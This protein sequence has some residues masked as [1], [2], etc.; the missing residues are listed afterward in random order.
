MIQFVH[1]IWYRFGAD[2]IVYCTHTGS[3]VVEFNSHCYQSLAAL[4]QMRGSFSRFCR[5]VIGQWEIINP[6]MEISSIVETSVNFCKIT[7]CRSHKSSS[8]SPLSEPEISPKRDSSFI[9]SFPGDVATPLML[10]KRN[11]DELQG[12]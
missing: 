8:Y 9:H 3:L 2:T 7:R 1:S 6:K 4:V 12:I 5:K 10:R 11:G